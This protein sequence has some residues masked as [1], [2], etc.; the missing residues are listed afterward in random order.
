MVLC[1]LYLGGAEPFEI[2]DTVKQLLFRLSLVT[3]FR[4]PVDNFTLRVKTSPLAVDVCLSILGIDIIDVVADALEDDRHPNNARV[5][6][7]Q[8]SQP[9]AS[10]VD[11]RLK[12]SH[13][14]RST[15]GVTALEYAILHMSLD[16]VFQ[17]LRDGEDASLGAPIAYAAWRDAHTLLKPL[18][19]AGAQV[20]ARH[21]TG[22]TALHW[23]SI[24]LHLSFLKTMIELAADEIEWNAITPEGKT[25]LQ[26]AQESPYLCKRSDSE[27]AEFYA[28]LR[29]RIDL[30]GLD[31]DTSLSMP[32]AYPRNET[33]NLTSGRTV[34]LSSTHSTYS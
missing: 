4:Y 27:L 2:R 25:A 17:L 8:F 6:F 26:I 20:N 12:I 31:A 1:S 10:H 28:L 23:A 7:S 19:E 24:G 16:D 30:D 34:Q 5:L 21:S 18:L 11:S 32:G 9:N 22:W 13:F 29:S 3:L 14:V 33:A 15:V